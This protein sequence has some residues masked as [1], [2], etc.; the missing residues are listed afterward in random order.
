[1]KDPTK[2]FR[3]SN[4]EDW[5]KQAAKNL[6]KLFEKVDI[7]QKTFGE[8]WGLGS[9]GMI[10]QYIN[11]KRPIG[12]PA[13]I[14]FAKGLNVSIAE[15]SPTLAAQLSQAP[16]NPENSASKQPLAD[17]SI[18]SYAINIKSN[19]R[20]ALAAP[21]VVA[22]LGALLAQVEST[23]AASVAGL[24]A[25]F[26]RSPGDAWLAGMLAKALGPVAF[27]QTNQRCG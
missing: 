7:S 16:V 18:A 19:R 3:A 11:A 13:A 21:D 20:G 12:L 8:I 24:L 5:E 15:I 9:G 26:A 22:A 2:S 6:K 25:D 27:T 14:K 10:S 23:R 1:M 17:E 4:L